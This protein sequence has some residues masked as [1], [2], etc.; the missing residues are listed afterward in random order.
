MSGWYVGLFLPIFLLLFSYFARDGAS[1]SQST[2]SVIGDLATLSN[3][4]TE[5]SSLKFILAP[6]LQSCAFACIALNL[7][8]SSLG[9]TRNIDLQRAYALSSHLWCGENNTTSATACNFD[10]RPI[11]CEN[12]FNVNDGIARIDLGSRNCS[13]PLSKAGESI[14]VATQ[15]SCDTPG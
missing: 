7:D 1:P 4:S 8:C 10:R 5:S 13:T 3:T 6:P 9:L 14:I 12:I 2:E 11:V 15:A